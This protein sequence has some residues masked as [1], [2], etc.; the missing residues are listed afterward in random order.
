MEHLPTVTMGGPTRRLER[1]KRELEGY[2]SWEANSSM[3]ALEPQPAPDTYDNWL[4]A[5]PVAWSSKVSWI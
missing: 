1:C 4:K 3:A 2:R 5:L